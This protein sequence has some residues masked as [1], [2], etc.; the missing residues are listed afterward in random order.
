MNSIDDVIK[1]LDEIIDW[2]L[3]NQ[4]RA[5]YFASL[6]RRMTVAVKD[7]IERGAFEDGPRMEKLDIIFAGRYFD[8]FD[9]WRAGN[10][11]THAWEVAFSATSENGLIVMQHLLLGI[12]AHI[13]LDLGIAAAKTCPGS[14][15]KS[16]ERDFMKINTVIS[17]LVG[18]VENEL[19]EIWFPLRWVKK[20]SGGLDKGIVNFSI[21][22][23]RDEAW[24]VATSLAPM[25]IQQQE[26]YINTLDGNIAA[27][28]NEVKSPGFFI[29]LALKFVRWGEPKDIVK[30]IKILD[31]HRK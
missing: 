6:Y 7:G 11:P 17:S 23:A 25:N 13:N 4:S 12:N 30:I 29:G 2:S 14:A 9:A 19:S 22:V 24:K 26:A 8:A 31:R 5:G 3:Q 18:T 10:K 27:L 21:D 1:R 16:L 15:I 28:G 20:L